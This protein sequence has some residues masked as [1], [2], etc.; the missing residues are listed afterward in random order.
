MS[1]STSLA[2]SLV[3]AVL[4]GSLLAQT[5]TIASA[6]GAG[7]NLLCPGGRAFI[8][9][10]SLG[11]ESAVVTVG[12]K[13]AYV[14][15]ANGNSFL[16]VQLPV[17]A[18]LGPTTLKVGAS[19]PFNITLVQYAPGVLT[20]GLPD[21]IAAAVHY[22]SQKSVTVS[23]PATPGE[24]IEL[25]VNG[26]G[27]TN[28]PVPTGVSPS[29]TNTVTVTLPSITLA[30]KSA[31]V[32]T[33]FLS[34]PGIY[35]VVFTVPA[36]ASA[37]NLKIAVGI[38]AVTSGTALLPVA[39]GPVISGISNA[40]SYIDLSL[41]NGGI[42]Q[43]SIFVIQGSNLGP[44]SLTTDTKTTFQN[45]TLAGTSVNVT[46]NGTAVP[47]LLYY[48]SA[49]QIAALLPSNVPTGAGTVA[50]TY[51]NQTGPSHPVRVVPSGLGIFTATSDGQGAGIVT[52][53]DYSLVSTVRAANCGGPYTTCGAANPGDVLTIWATGLGPINGKDAA[54]DGLGVNMPNVPLTVWLGNVSVT[55]SYQGRGCCIGEDQIIFTVPANAPTG[56][57]VP[58]SLQVNNFISNVVELPVAPAGTRACIPSDPKF[59]AGT[60]QQVTGGS[61]P[62]S[63][64][65][66]DLKHVDQQ[67]GFQDIFTGQF[68]RFSV[69]SAVQPFFMSYVDMPPLGTC[70]VIN[71]LNGGNPPL[72]PLASLD[73]GSQISVRGP[74]GTQNAPASSGQFKTTLSSSGNFLSPG[75][76]TVSAPGGA[77]VPAFSASISIPAMPAMT[78]PPPDAPNPV[79]ATRANGLTVNWSGGSQA[80]YVQI[81]VFSAT[82]YTYTNGAD[83]ICSASASA[84][85]FTV[86]PSAMLALPA[87][88]FAG[89]G[90]RPFA[91]PVIPIGTGVNVPFLSA[92]YATFTSL[93]L[94]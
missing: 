68:L 31:K 93:S 71:T 20:D 43:G 78:S 19:A 26:L 84:G 47:A 91:A 15:G 92:W 94:K 81:E 65:E 53:P 28:P 5:P 89:L 6:S 46:V 16:D 3:S 54:G 49:N 55:A 34:G 41:P 33:A 2:I 24:Q 69:A 67:P 64:A 73:F 58:L 30:G 12:A 36:D 59:P 83:L 22:S 82:D 9:G 50:V 60:V 35:A 7:T 10:T 74:S 87:G 29:D 72:T 8:Q 27:P 25:F 61:G 23:A 14:R 11:G 76:Y 32:S 17:D 79:A 42:A 37:G 38:G 48:T 52:Y 86:P 56:C 40:A 57:A 39:T 44:A 13:Q 66:I 80:A 75:T 70:A 88:N 21:D 90:F 18:P 4:C 63:Y 62:F 1:T 85:T 77:D 45:M 51:N